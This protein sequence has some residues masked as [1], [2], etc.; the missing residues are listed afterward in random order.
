M[1]NVPVQYVLYLIFS[2]DATPNDDVAIIGVPTV[3]VSFIFK[4]LVL[5]PYPALV[6]EL[7][8][9]I[10]QITPALLALL[11]ATCSKS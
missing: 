6:P 10:Q 2:A 5:S 7:P 11:I 1:L 3:V 4:I 8:A 9:D